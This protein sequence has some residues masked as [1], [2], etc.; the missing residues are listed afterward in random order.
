[1]ASREDALNAKARE[2]A[3]TLKRALEPLPDAGFTLFLFDMSEG[4]PPGFMAYISNADRADMIKAVKEWLRVQE[5]LR[6][7]PGK[8]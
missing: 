2:I 3:Q 4:G 8:A 5:A 6:K 7:T 1:M